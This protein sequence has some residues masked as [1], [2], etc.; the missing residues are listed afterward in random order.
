VAIPGKPVLDI[1]ASAVTVD[2]AASDDTQEWAQTI[3]QW[4]MEPGS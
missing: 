4:Q 1:S 3:E 2:A